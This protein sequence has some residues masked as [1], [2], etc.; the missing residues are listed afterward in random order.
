MHLLADHGT[1]GHRFSVMSSGSGRLAEVCLW[2]LL[3]LL[4]GLSLQGPG[5]AMTQVIPQM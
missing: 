4:G 2:F 5:P 1:D 3:S